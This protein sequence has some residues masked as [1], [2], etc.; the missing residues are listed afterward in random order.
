MTPTT[1]PAA[2]RPPGDSAQIP[3]LQMAPQPKCSCKGLLRPRRMHALAGLWMT[4]F[5]FAHLAIVVTGWS[6]AAYGRNASFIQGTLAGLPAFT[7]V[8]IFLPLLFQTVSG[9]YL[10]RKEGM[11]YNVKKCNRGGKVRFFLQRV[12]GL[13]ILA[14]GLFHLGTIHEWGLHTVY[15]ATHLSALSG[16]SAGGLFQAGAPF[17]STAQAFGRFCGTS[18]AGNLL[19]AAFLL[20]GIWAAVFHTANGAWTGAGIWNLIPTPESKRRWRFV[21]IAIGTVLFVAGTVAW[22]AF[23]LSSAARAF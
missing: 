7:M 13:V 12:T 20:L 15:R 11:R 17:R 5:L 4:G 22:S 18:A 9:L 16:Y 8:A 23:T 14:F 3:Q 19:V 1:E 10:L 2:N 21:C 6:P